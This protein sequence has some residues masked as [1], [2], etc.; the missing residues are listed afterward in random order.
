MNEQK[1][2]IWIL[3]TIICLSVIWKEKT[4][5]SG[6]SSWLAKKVKNDALKKKQRRRKRLRDFL[7]DDMLRRQM[8]KEF[9]EKMGV[10]ECAE[11]MKEL[12]IEASREVTKDDI[13]VSAHSVMKEAMTR[14]WCVFTGVLGLFYI[15]QFLSIAIFLQAISALVLHSVDNFFYYSRR[16]RLNFSLSFLRFFCWAGLQYLVLAFFPLVLDSEKDHSAILY[17][18]VWF[19]F[20]L[21]TSM[22]QIQPKAID[23]KTAGLAPDSDQSITHQSSLLM[24]V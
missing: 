17:I 23:T 9:E 13:H 21:F 22:S 6:G 14:I 19:A 11:H 5:Q 15:M 12:E 1:A 18:V 24:Q 20:S 3:W 16:P 8:I 7:S 4:T 10:A 2:P